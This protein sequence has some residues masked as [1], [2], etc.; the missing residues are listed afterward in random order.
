[1]LMGKPEESSSTENAADQSGARSNTTDF[2]RGIFY[3][4]EKNLCGIKHPDPS[5]LAIQ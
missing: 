5:V 4:N 2:G 3:M 1:M